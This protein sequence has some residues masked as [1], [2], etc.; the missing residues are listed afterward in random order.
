MQYENQRK[1]LIEKAKEI[2]SRL[3]AIKKDL[4]K[5]YNPDSSEQ[6][7]ERENDEVLEALAVGCEQ[8][9]GRINKALL[10]IDDESY[11]Q[12]A[13]CGEAIGESRL[14]INPEVDLCIDCAE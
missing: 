1:K 9:L 12:C 6:A 14:E 8:Q 10:R 4:K 13:Q 3:E 5:P 11:G 2:S 7:T